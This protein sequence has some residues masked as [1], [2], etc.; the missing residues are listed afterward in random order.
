MAKSHLKQPIKKGISRKGYQ[1]ILPL[2]DK[3][4]N[5]FACTNNSLLQSQNPKNQAIR[6][7]L[8]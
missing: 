7:Y 3:S 5:N 8:S 1:R 6:N 4:T 2:G